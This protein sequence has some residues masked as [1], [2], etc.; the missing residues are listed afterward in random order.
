MVQIS[1]YQSL[2]GQ[3]TIRVLVDTFYDLMDTLPEAA[4]I[5]ELHPSDLSSAREKLYEFLCGWSGGP[6]LYMEKYGHPRLRMRHLP[7]PIGAAE[8]DQW[9]LCM[10]RALEQV[11]ED[12]TIRERL[13]GS[14]YQI[15]D[16]MQNKEQD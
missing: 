13:E 8:R 9:M 2:G 11:V 7:F 1:L 10:R 15:A 5:R 14:F 4:P 12:K 16:F 3:P 6:Q